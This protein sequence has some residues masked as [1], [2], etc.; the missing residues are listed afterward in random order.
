VNESVCPE[1]SQFPADS[2]RTSATEGVTITRQGEAIARLVPV[3]AR[4]QGRRVS[5]PLIRS[6]GNPRPLAPAMKNPHDLIL[7]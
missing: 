6:K 7:P 3:A 1:H 4:R 5:F 2:G